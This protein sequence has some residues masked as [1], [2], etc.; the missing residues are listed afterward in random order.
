LHGAT[1]A[2][3]S[4]E[5]QIVLLLGEERGPSARLL[6]YL[7][8]G[9][10]DGALVVSHHRDDGVA[11]LLA[12]SDLPSVFIGRPWSPDETPVRYVDVD[13]V[14]GG[15]LAAQHLLER[16]VRRPAML[17]GP[18]DMG[19]PADRVAGWQGALAA[20]GLAAGP[21]LHADFSYDG[22]ARVTER[23]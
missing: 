6:S 12:D 4:T 14:A 8:G 13:N 23:L 16:G 21:V 15:R 11:R 19:G 22:A 1:A 2:L 17:A 9:H 10:C 20:A 18:A 7:A 5:F 3:S